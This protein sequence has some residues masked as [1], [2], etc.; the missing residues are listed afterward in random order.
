MSQDIMV[1]SLKKNWTSKSLSY[2]HE[3][4]ISV[5]EIPNITIM[6]GRKFVIVTE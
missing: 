1:N 6:N 4:E 3:I 5:L 2:N